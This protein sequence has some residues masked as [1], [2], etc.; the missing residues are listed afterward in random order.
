M[1]I[2][3]MLCTFC[4]LMIASCVKGTPPEVA[5]TLSRQNMLG[6]ESYYY[7]Q[8]SAKS[9]K[10]AFLTF[11]T[12]IVAVDEYR[13][14]NEKSIANPKG[15]WVHIILEGSASG[16]VPLTVVAALQQ[17]A[18]ERYR[19]EQNLRQRLERPPTASDQVEY[20]DRTN[21]YA[22]EI[23]SQFEKGD[24]DAL[25]SV[26]GAPSHVDSF[27]S[28][29]RRLKVFEVTYPDKFFRFAHIIDTNSILFD[30][31]HLRATNEPILFGIGIG[32]PVEDIS[33]VF[34]KPSDLRSDML[35][36]KTDSFELIFRL[37]EKKVIEID[38]QHNVD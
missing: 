8:P 35:V 26:Y 34:G 30:Q 6:M 18:V 27:L 20:P 31:T 12:P 23:V 22:E 13:L 14:T 16:W 21:R 29:N 5:E 28:N 15:I 38:L 11:G 3:R 25:T 7:T 36:F 1:H 17:E 10:S 9:E 33:K 19:I 37:E 24:L 2:R 32:T 4:L